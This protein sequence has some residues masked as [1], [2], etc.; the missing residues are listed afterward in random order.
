MFGFIKRWRGLQ[1]YRCRDCGKAFYRPLSPTER[2]S[3][4]ASELPARKNHADRSAARRRRQ[5]RKIE[6]FVFF[7]MLVIFYAALRM[8]TR[9]S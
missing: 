8:L 2:R 1:R 9:S 6:L 3:V 7:G 5:R 4:E